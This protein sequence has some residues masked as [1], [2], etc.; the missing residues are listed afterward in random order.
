MKSKWNNCAGLCGLL[1]ILV[2]G[3]AVAQEAVKHRVLCVD[4]GKN[5]LIL[6][7]QI[8][9]LKSWARPIPAGSRDLQIVAMKD[10]KADRVLVSHGNG[11]AEYDLST[12]NP[13]GWAVSRY[14]SIQTA[15]RL[16]NGHTLLGAGDGKVYDVDSAGNE[17]GVIQPQEKFDIRLM[18]LL[19]ND[20]LLMSGAAVKCILE[21]DRKGQIL[22][23]FPLPGK[24]Y[25]AVRLPD[26]HYIS[27]TG[28][29]C[30]V[31]ELDAAGKI[32]N[33]VGGKTEHP[34]LGLDFVSGWDTLP[35]G[36]I[37]VANWLGHGKQGKGYHLV[38][39]SRDNK[40]VWKWQDHELAKQITNVLFLE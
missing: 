5:Q 35:N 18:R 38:E 6:V 23:R 12:G 11:A 31:V 33:S 32:L 25:K 19:E 2:A 34:E 1:T 40:V 28:D 15:L 37:L 3:S 36:N 24:G 26:G 29:A 8:N 20:N 9:P 16:A 17:T 21:M 27:S 39:F 4:N 13:S 10:G 7:D 22:K 30:L 14:G